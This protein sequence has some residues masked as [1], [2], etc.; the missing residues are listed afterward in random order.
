M[1]CEDQESASLE[2]SAG[3]LTSDRDFTPAELSAVV[4]YLAKLNDMCVA[5]ADTFGETAR[6]RAAEIAGLREALSILSQC[7]VL[8]QPESLH[9]VCVQR[10]WAL[11]HEY[12]ELDAVMKATRWSIFRVLILEV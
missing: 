7:A 2:K 6:R 5:K 10:H 3:K 4:E 11:L 1:K 8:Q 12:V 9:R